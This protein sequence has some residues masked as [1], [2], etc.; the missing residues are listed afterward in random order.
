MKRSLSARLVVAVLAASS[1]V[2]V[3]GG[4][5][6]VTMVN[7]NLAEQGITFGE[8]TEWAGD[9]VDDGLDA[10]HFQDV[11]QG[12]VQAALEPAGFTTYSA[13][14]QAALATM[15]QADPA[16]DPALMALRRTALDGELLRAAL[17]SSFAWWLVGWVGIAAGLALAVLAAAAHR[18]LRPREQQQDLRLSPRE[19]VDLAV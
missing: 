17:L 16:G 10:Y 5:A 8:D 6:A 11:V 9:R 19:A 12:H 7:S 3:T 4:T 13:V 15:T 2:G 14:S 1:A 18:V